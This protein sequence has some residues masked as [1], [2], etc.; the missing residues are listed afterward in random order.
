[1]RYN[2]SE[3]ISSAHYLDKRGEPRT[4][5]KYTHEPLLTKYGAYQCI[6][7][8]ESNPSKSTEG[9]SISKAVKTHLI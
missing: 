1:M 4:H 8:K 3:M 2:R 7:G 5:K 6:K 9:W